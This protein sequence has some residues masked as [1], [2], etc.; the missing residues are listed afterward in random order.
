MRPC[1]LK[2]PKLICWCLWNERNY[3]IF[4]EKTQH[5]WKTT[6]KIKAL[7]GEVV[8]I[9]KIPSNKG[10]LTD[11]EKEWMQSLN[12]MAVNIVDAKKLEEWDIRMDN[13][14]FENWLKERKFFKLFFDGASKGNP[15]KVGGGGVIINPNGKVEV[16]YSWNIGYDTNNMA[17][18]YG[19]WQGLKQLR[20]KKVDKV[21]VF[22][23]S[24]IIIQ[25]M[26]GGRRSDNI[27]IA[28]LIRRIRS[29]IKL[30]RKVYF[31]H[32]LRD[33]NVLADTAANKAI[34]AD[35]NDL[36]VNSVVRNDIP[37]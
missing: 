12:P 9:S 11:K 34:V 18:A 24:R 26:N 33:L 14:Q 7:L 23:D 19:L 35:L 10:I 5:L 25:A 36:M 21:M 4:Q 30:F 3:R 2:I 13:S 37:P 16:E 22:G 8:S 1:W 29:I 28:R 15:G 6:I 17:E 32:I 20:V 31:Y 27:R